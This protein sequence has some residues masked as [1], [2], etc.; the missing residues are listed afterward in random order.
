[1]KLGK[2]IGTLDMILRIGISGFLIYISLIDTQFISDP[3][4]SGVFAVLGVVNLIVALIRYCPLYSLI[5]VN[6]CKLG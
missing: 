4:S 5:R 3:F 2:N 6:T 1:M